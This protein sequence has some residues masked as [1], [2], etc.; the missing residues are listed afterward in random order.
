MLNED[1]LLDVDPKTA[2]TEALNNLNSAQLTLSNSAITSL[3]ALVQD[4]FNQ[5]ALAA[6]SSAIF[7][8][9]IGKFKEV[10]EL[11][12]SAQG[13]QTTELKD[14]EE[15][16]RQSSNFLLKFI[17]QPAVAV[18]IDSDMF[19]LLTTALLNLLPA[20]EETNVSLKQQNEK[21]F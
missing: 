8:A 1:E 3:M 16:L 17:P 7:M 9:V 5:K 2:I 14:C 18:N 10:S 19:E 15:Y 11:Y 20:L 12:T 6:K 4:T 21:N 13:E